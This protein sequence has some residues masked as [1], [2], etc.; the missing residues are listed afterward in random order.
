MEYYCSKCNTIMADGIFNTYG[1]MF[2][3]VK[4]PEKLF[5]NKKSAI[6]VHVCPNCG[7]IEL[8]AREPEKFKE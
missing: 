1:S 4:K 8:Y 3:I 6:D 7:Y 2:S 5:G